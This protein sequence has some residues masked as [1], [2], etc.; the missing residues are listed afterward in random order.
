MRLEK[1]QHNKINCEEEKQFNLFII[2]L[3]VWVEMS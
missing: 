1:K 2:I 3:E